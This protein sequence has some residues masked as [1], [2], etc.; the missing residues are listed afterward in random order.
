MSDPWP[1]IIVIIVLA[2]IGALISLS[3]LLP[4][5]RRLCRRSLAARGVAICTVGAASFV[6]GFGLLTRLNA[7]VA[8]L[9][10]TMVVVDTFG[11]GPA[12]VSW[13]PEVEANKPYVVR[14]L[15]ARLLIPPGTRRPCYTNEAWVCDAADDVV[16]AT[17]ERWDWQPYLRD[18][19]IGC[20]P[21]VTSGLL[22]WFFT[23][24]RTRRKR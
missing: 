2:F 1:F 8:Y 15:W 9:F 24:K 18:V 17:S 5:M 6:I 14:E 21:A 12:E 11:P 23:R 10:G 22:G 3:A 4:P 7:E 16:P 13:P 20:V 19:G